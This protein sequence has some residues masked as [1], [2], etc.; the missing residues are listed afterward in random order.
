MKYPMLIRYAGRAVARDMG[1]EQAEKIMQRAARYDEKLK[2]ENAA[3]SKVLR[4]HTFKRIYPAI[5]MYR[6]L[7]KAGVDSDKAIWYI[8]QYYVPFCQKAAKGLRAIVALPGVADRLPGLFIRIASKGF[9]ESAGFEYDWPQ[10]PERTTGF[11]MVACPYFETCKRYGCPE[12]TKIFC[13][14]DD[15]TYGHMHPR[16]IWGRTTTLGH[17]GPY[18]DFRLTLKEK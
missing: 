11:N 18:C 6:S 2:R 13:D 16:L 9:P 3:D 15:I 17:G 5:A 12:L 14:A 7:Q 4:K 1:Q 10:M 8:N